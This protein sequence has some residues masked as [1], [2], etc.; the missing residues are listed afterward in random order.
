[1]KV[2]LQRR[3]FSELFDIA[4]SAA[5]GTAK[6]SLGKVLFVVGQK[7]ELQASNGDT[8][9]IVDCDFVHGD[10]GK[11]LLDPRRISAILK[12]SSGD[13][14]TIEADG[15][16]IRITTAEG[17]YS[18]QSSDPAEFPRV[19][20]NTA[21]PVEVASTA[22]LEAL[23]LTSF[24]VDNGFI[25]YQLGG[26]CFSG[27]SEGLNLV[28]TDG[29]RLSTVAIPVG[30]DLNGIV[31][32][33]PLGLLMRCLSNDNETCGISFDSSNA[34]FQTGNV[35]LITRLV[36]GRYPNW[37]SVVPSAEGCETINLQAS[38]F[39]QAVK[40]ASI[41]ADS[42]SR[43]IVFA[44]GDGNCSISAKQADVGNSSVSVPVEFGGSYSAT[45]DYR[46]VLDWFTRLP[47]GE[48]V[49]MHVKTSTHPTLFVRGQARYVVMPM[50]SR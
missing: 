13:E 7:A 5:N 33:K 45:L 25:R 42:E 44:F 31:P 26:V 49:T 47:K 41:V 14:V 29:R 28:A 1:M 32:S 24:A 9:V 35:T 16:S 38:A 15:S 30:C 12:E 11:V 21:E 4:A 43:G 34:S 20:A 8:S 22:L 10:A 27:D 23:T 2:V 6:D 50:E 3:K 40:Q 36:D 48:T 39:T 46:F 19:K 17:S 18:L 37:K